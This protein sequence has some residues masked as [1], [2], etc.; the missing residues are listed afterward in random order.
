MILKM[1]QEKKSNWEFD[2]PNEKTIM[3]DVSKEEEGVRRILESK[4]NNL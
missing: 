4:N 2:H 1:N 3:L